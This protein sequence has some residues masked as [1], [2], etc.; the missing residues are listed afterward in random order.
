MKEL[1]KGWIRAP[2]H[3]LA[4]VQLGRQRSPKNH[5]GTHMRPYM[6]AA[7]VTWNGLDLSDVKE[8]NFDPDEAIRFELQPGDLLLA[9]ASGSAS[10]VGKPVLW[11][12]EVPGACFQNTLLRVQTFGPLP[13]YLLHY[14][15]HLAVTGAFA[16]GS[17]GVGIHHLGKLA[18]EQFEI[19]IAPIAEQ[20]R[21]VDAIEEYFSRINAGVEVLMSTGTKAAMALRQIRKSVLHDWPTVPLSE[22][23]EVVSGNTPKGLVD[24]PG[25]TIPFYK[26]G[27][28]NNNDGRIMTTARTWIDEPARRDLGIHVRPAG[29]VIFPKRGGAIATN[30]KRK[31][32]GPAAFDLNTMGVI[33]G[34]DLM[35]DYLMEWFETVDLGQLS[36]GSNVPQ[37]NHGDIR[38]LRI[39][40][41]P[42]ADQVR[43]VAEINQARDA[44]L[45]GS[46]VIESALKRAV[47]LRRAVL[48]RAFSGRLVDQDPRDEPAWSLLERS[49]TTRGTG[50]VTNPGRKKMK[51]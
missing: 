15:N 12:G 49:L 25:G 17:R 47:T 3:E 27:D 38:P 22:V 48:A 23:A 4:K 5:Q 9:E 10:E 14:F 21:I 34:D 51:V 32:A 30:K 42:L 35:D 1:P 43:A 11:K 45:R 16:E 24:V 20:R 18:M 31:L 7:N 6:R 33:P 2:L 28:M 39:P 46:G 40:L 29:T 8:M 50:G 13:E 41:P 37:I 19:P 26:V 44:I 36:D